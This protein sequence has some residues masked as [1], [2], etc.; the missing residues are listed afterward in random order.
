MLKQ[1]LKN[2]DFSAE[3]GSSKNYS[4]V[5]PPPNITGILHMGHGL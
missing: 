4:I 1:W 5:I 2:K 3:A